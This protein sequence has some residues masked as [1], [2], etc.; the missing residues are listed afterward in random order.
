[1]EKRSFRM[2]IIVPVVICVPGCPLTA[3][4][5]VYGILQLQ[6]KIKRRNAANK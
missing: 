3:E 4:V 1:M 5:L 2:G 6:K